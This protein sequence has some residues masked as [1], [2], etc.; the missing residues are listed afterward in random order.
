MSRQP[1]RPKNRSGKRPTGK[2]P[3]G[4]RPGGKRSRSDESLLPP[5]TAPIDLWTTCTL[6]GLSL[7]EERM[8]RLA[9]YAEDLLYWNEKVNLISR[10][11]IPHLW[12]RHILHSIT[13]VLAGYVPETGRMLDIGTGGGLPGIPIKIVRPGL[14]VVLLDSIAKKVRTTSMIAS[15]VAE[16]GLSAIRARAEELAEDPAHKGSYDIVVARAVAPIASL[17]DWA[18]PL[19]KPTGFALFLKGGRLQREVDESAQRHPD[20]SI[21]IEPI[22]LKGTDWFTKQEKRIV[23]ARPNAATMPID[24][25]GEND[26]STAT[27]EGGEEVTPEETSPPGASEDQSEPTG[28][29]GDAPSGPSLEDPTTAG[30]PDAGTDGTVDTGTVEPGAVGDGDASSGPPIGTDGIDG[31]TT[32]AGSTTGS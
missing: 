15:H 4:N 27:Q 31:T 3:G 5:E 32:G 17:L 28:V 19:L 22:E 25:V 7:E 23:I 13:P 16:H 18:R 29:V 14:D 12:E 26:R 8:G 10:K 1:S 20:V 21:T 11:D 6:N 2:R 30:V 24:H 9:R